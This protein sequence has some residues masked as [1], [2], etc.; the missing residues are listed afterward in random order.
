M[1]VIDV[2][3]IDER[4]EFIATYEI[5]PIKKSLHRIERRLFIF[6]PTADRRHTFDRKAQKILLSQ[7]ALLVLHLKKDSGRYRDAQQG[8]DT[9]RQVFFYRRHAQPSILVIFIQ[10]HRSASDASRELSSFDVAVKA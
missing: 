1:V 2:Q 9:D 7:L 5:G 10:R 3:R 4:L 6:K 8:R